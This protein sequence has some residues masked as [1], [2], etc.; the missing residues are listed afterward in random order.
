MTIRR[1]RRRDQ[2]ASLHSDARSRRQTVIRVVYFT[3]ILALA[4]WLGD[5]FLGGFLYLRIAGQ[6]LAEPSVVAVEF[7]VTVRDIKVH[8]GE[9]VAA[10][11]V[12][13]VVSSQNVAETLA[14]LTAEQAD[15]ALRLSELRIRD[16]TVNAVLTLAQTRQDQAIETRRKMEALLAGGGFLPLDKR[17]AALESEFRSRQDLAQ[18]S[19]EKVVLAGEITDLTHAMDEAARAIGELSRMYDDG[20]VRAAIDG[21]VGRRMAEN[22]TVLQSGQPLL[23]LYKDRRF[24]LA[25]LPTGRLFSVAPG[26]RIVISTGLQSFPGT[27]SS[28][29]PV[30][31]LPPAEFRRAFT[32]VDRQQLIQISFDADQVPP[33]LFTKVEVRSAPWPWVDRLIGQPRARS[34]R[35]APGCEPSGRKARSGRAVLSGCRSP[36]PDR[37]PSPPPGP[38]P[39]LWT[40]GGR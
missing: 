7:P 2:P 19:A 10:G 14:R 29:E 3:S 5:L 11:Q 15:R 23:E 28:I 17:F 26:D 16:A 1:L 40:D 30:A 33:P 34:V 12:V 27:I 8:E 21:I 31:A 35:S 4:L 38:R 37:R 18:R 22:G 6:V 39:S 32:P 24:V 9:R 25:F 20:K 13:A 36:R